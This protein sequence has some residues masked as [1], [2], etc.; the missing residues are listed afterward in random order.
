MHVY[1]ATTAR[2]NLYTLGALHFQI[3]IFVNVLEIFAVESN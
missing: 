2:L 3:I 1:L